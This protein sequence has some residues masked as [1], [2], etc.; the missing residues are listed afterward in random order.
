MKMKLASKDYY[1]S[2]NHKQKETIIYLKISK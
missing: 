1:A 2:L